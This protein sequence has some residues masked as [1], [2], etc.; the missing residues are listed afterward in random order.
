VLSED[1]ASKLA[2]LGGDWRIAL[3]FTNSITQPGKGESYSLLYESVL[4]RNGDASSYPARRPISATLDS[5][6]C[7]P[8]FERNPFQ[9]FWG[10]LALIGLA[11]SLIVGKLL[12]DRW[13]VDVAGNLQIL[14]PNSTQVVGRATLSGR[15]T[16]WFSIDGRQKVTP[17]KSDSGKNW[18]LRV[19]GESTMLI[20]PEAGQA[21]P[22]SDGTIAKERGRSTRFVEFRRVP[23]FGGADTYTIRY[24][25]EA[26]SA[27]ADR[28]NNEEES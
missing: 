13:N 12:F 11:I 5:V 24:T 22:W 26:D 21:G 20:T 9:K 19:E 27:L 25:P 15:R 4:L 17:G 14:D 18:S 1:Q 28:I 16:A 6:P 2:S 8:L 7:A 10:L 3:D 23:I